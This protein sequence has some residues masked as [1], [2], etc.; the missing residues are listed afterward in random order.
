MVELN[1]FTKVYNKLFTCCNYRIIFLFSSLFHPSRLKRFTLYSLY[2]MNA[3]YIVYRM[4]V[5]CSSVVENIAVL[6]M[7]IHTTRFD[8]SVRDTEQ[9]YEVTS[10][11]NALVKSFF[12][13]SVILYISALCIWTSLSLYYFFLLLYIFQRVFILFSHYC[14]SDEYY[15]WY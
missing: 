12:L 15:W 8:A 1:F 9:C 3:Y 10:A 2:T 5:V 13:L 11:Q 6:Q 7:S 4:C 14:A